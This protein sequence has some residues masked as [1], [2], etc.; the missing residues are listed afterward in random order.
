MA[1]KS[2]EAPGNSTGR[3]GGRLFKSAALLVLSLSTLVVLAT[4]AIFTD[5]ASVGSNAF[6]AGTV[7]ISSLPASALLS[8]NP[9]APGDAL[10]DDLTVSNS[11]TLALRYS[12]KSTTTGSSV[13]AGQLDLTI[14]DEAE[15]SDGGTTC[16]ASAPSTVLYGP[17]DLGSAGGTNVIGNPSQGSQLGDRSLSASASDVLCFKVSLP[18]ASDNTFQGLLTTATFDF[19]AEQTANN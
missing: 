12:V 9:M 3:E 5:T 19:A 4:G 15:E 18:L 16:N 13:L 10:V 11:G 8:M 1:R 7:D 17:A 6:Q 14:W 2:Q